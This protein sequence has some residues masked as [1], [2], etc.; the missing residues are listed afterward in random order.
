VKAVLIDPASMTAVWMNEAAAQDLADADRESVPGLPIDQAVPL[1]QILGV[2]EALRAAA[3]TGAAQ[4]L[5][6][7]LVSTAQGSVAIVAS[8][9]CLPDGNLLLLM[10]H[11]WR[12][13]HANKSPDSSRGS[14]RRA[15]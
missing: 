5:Q 2:P 4:S 11:A 1:A 10:E 9:Y 15:R 13:K 3:D 12:A 6:A 7:S 8:V 14:R